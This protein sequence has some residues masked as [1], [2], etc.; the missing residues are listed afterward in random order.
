MSM[1]FIFLPIWNYLDTTQSI[2]FR[3]F[4]RACKSPAARMNA[5]D[6]G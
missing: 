5:S 3:R 2:A 4:S 6:P 1:T